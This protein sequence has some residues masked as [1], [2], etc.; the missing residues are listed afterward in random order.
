MRDL[1]NHIVTKRAISPAAA[2]ADNTPL[3]SEIIDLNG[4]D[5][6]MFSILIGAIV[7]ADAT[8]VVLIE[9]GDQANLS[10]AAPALDSQLTGTEL[11]AGFRY[12]S[13]NQT[14][15]IGYVGPKR[16]VRMTITPANNSANAFI[17]AEAILSGSRYS[18]AN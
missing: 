2:V 8:F 15:K 12:D 14:R 10:D 13:D 17:A 3:V 5:K 9:H 4:Y 11:K 6:A 7:D 18:L 16:Y 1:A